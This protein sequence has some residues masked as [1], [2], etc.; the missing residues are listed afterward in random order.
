MIR[1]SERCRDL[2]GRR[3]RLLHDVTTRGGTTYEAARIMIVTNTWRGMFDL[4]VTPREE[5]MAARGQWR[6]VMKVCRRDF[7]VVG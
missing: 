5:L 4:E 7:E 6:G 1:R 3:V 2:V